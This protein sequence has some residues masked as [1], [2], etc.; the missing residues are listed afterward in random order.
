M[1]GKWRNS[2][3]APP[4][5]EFTPSV[6]P[7]QLS[8]DQGVLPDAYP[9]D[10]PPDSSAVATADESAAPAALDLHEP[11]E[12]VELPLVTSGLGWPGTSTPRRWERRRTVDTITLP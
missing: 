6:V 4:K 12:R 2:Y 3:T 5:L 1:R 11:L 7:A 8:R 9:V 10:L